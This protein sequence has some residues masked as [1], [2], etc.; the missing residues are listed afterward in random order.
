MSPWIAFVIFGHFLA[1][2]TKVYNVCRLERL[3]D[4]FSTILERKRVVHGSGVVLGTFKGWKGLLDVR[5]GEVGPPPL[6]LSRL[7]P[8]GTTKI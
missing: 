7:P 6:R 3:D 5:A 8:H 2:R 1:I 4:A